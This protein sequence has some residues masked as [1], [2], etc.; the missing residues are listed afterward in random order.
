M[1]DYYS[2]LGVPFDAEPE[3]IKSVYR[4]LSKIYHP[5]Q[6]VGDKKF[7]EEKFK[8][9]NEAYECLKNTKKRKDYDKEFNKEFNKNKYNDFKDSDKKEESNFSATVKKDWDVIIEFY[10]EIELERQ[11]LSKIDKRIGMAFQVAILG[12]KSSNNWKKV[13]KIV[14]DA[15]FTKYFGSESQIHRFVELLL[16][17]KKIKIAN[18]VNR[19]VRVLGDNDPETIITKIEEKYE[20]KLEFVDDNVIENWHNYFEDYEY[21]N[22]EEYEEFYEWLNDED[23]YEQEER[24]NYKKTEPSTPF[25]WRAVIGFIILWIL[26]VIFNS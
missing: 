22:H 6:Y 3:L 26:L 12:Y 1:K 21:R 14:V 15:F 18:E 25:I 16:L 17:E 19:A 2:I 9:I 10:E 23:N 4:S 8:D 24:T 7:A 5:D 13:S 20:D 11:H